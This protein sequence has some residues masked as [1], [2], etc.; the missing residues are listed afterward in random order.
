MLVL[1]TAINL[2]PAAAWLILN[3]STIK[4]PTKPVSSLCEG[5]NSLNSYLKKNMDTKCSKYYSRTGWLQ[6]C[7]FHFQFK[8]PSASAKSQEPSQQQEVGQ[9]TW[10]MQE[11]GTSVFLVSPHSHGQC[12][13]SVPDSFWEATLVAEMPREFEELWIDHITMQCPETPIQPG[14]GWGQNVPLAAPEHTPR[15]P[16]YR[17]QPG[18]TDEGLQG[19]PELRWF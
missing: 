9:K 7:G 14:R 4:Y 12:V 19:L 10:M 13:C 11:W 1:N 18:A 17:I 15:T 8:K 3:G 5:L 2:S 16:K 6:W